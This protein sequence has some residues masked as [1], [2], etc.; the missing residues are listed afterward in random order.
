VIIVGLILPF[1]RFPGYQLDIS[2]APIQ[3]E[4]KF[5]GR[6]IINPGYV[7]GGNTG[8]DGVAVLVTVLAKTRM[9]NQLDTFYYGL[10][11]R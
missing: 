7:R 8:R 2:S 1:S 10:T 6:S 5:D 11:P 4:G 9:G 3:L